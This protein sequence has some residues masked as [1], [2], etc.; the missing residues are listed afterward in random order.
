MEGG[1]IRE[2]YYL[3]GPSGTTR[4]F[5]VSLGAMMNDFG[6][7]IDTRGVWRLSH[8]VHVFVNNGM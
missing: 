5:S 8:V 7:K 3:P 6:F 2:I 4:L 1:K